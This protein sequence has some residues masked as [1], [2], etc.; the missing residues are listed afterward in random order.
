MEEKKKKKQ[1]E[2][3]KK[4]V[5]QKKVKVKIVHM[6]TNTHLLIKLQIVFESTSRHLSWHCMCVGHTVS[7]LILQSFLIIIFNKINSFGWFLKTCLACKFPVNKH[8]PTTSVQCW[9]PFNRKNREWLE[10]IG[11]LYLVKLLLNKALS[12]VI[13]LLVYLHFWMNDKYLP[14]CIKFLSVFL[15]PPLQAAD[16]KPKGE[17]HDPVPYTLSSTSFSKT[18]FQQL[19]YINQL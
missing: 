5:A 2:K 10:K 17:C 1:E 7:A 11:S 8:P 3:T 14:C 9:L 12:F 13:T 4:D 16:Q 19:I 18:T 15:F 6:F